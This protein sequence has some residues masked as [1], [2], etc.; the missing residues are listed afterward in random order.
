MY[1]KI[2]QFS[3][4]RIFELSDLDSKILKFE[5]PKMDSWLRE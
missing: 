1:L 3:N 4:L 2:K 5:N